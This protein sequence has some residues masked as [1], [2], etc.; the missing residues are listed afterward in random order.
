MQVNN[1][2]ASVTNH[3]SS[4]LQV[5]GLVSGDRVDLYRFKVTRDSAV[6]FVAFFLRRGERGKR[7][8]F[9]VWAGFGMDWT[10]GILRNMEHFVLARRVGFG[11]LARLL[12][13]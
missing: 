7:C 1:S 10:M 3:E 8:M 11:L 12:V 6:H 13:T 5:R 9:G 4:Q 2:T